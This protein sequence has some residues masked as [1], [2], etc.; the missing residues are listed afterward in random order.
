MIEM[1]KYT[2]SNPL[3]MHIPK[4]M[5]FHDGLQHAAHEDHEDMQRRMHRRHRK[6]ME[7][8]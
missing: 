2:K 4:T 6:T 3:G 1:Y 8:L 7:L 5:K